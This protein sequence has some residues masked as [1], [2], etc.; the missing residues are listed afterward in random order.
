VVNSS[1]KSTA[2]KQRVQEQ[3]AKDAK[4]KASDLKK[5][6]KALK[7][8]EKGA[9]K[10]KKV[11]EAKEVKRKA[12]EEAADATKAK[13]EAKKS[14]TTKPTKKSS[15]KKA[16]VSSYD[17]DSDL[18]DKDDEVDDDD[19]DAD[20]DVDDESSNDDESESEEEEEEGSDN[21][22]DDSDDDDLLEGLT[23]E[24]L[25]RL[26]S[27]MANQKATESKG[28]GL[29]TLN[30]SSGLLT[31]FSN[32]DEAYMKKTMASGGKIVGEGGKVEV[33]YALPPAAR[34]NSGLKKKR[35]LPSFLTQ[36][37]SLE[38]LMASKV[39][40]NGVAPQGKAG[41]NFSIGGAQT[42]KISAAKMMRKM[43]GKKNY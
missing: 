23:P 17:E 24:E 6:E 8:A 12:E 39:G 37:P 26:Q 28:K 21:D 19:L 10:R 15:S 11:E 20:L 25:T 31:K 29:N 3:T 43:G 34:N 16:A 41:A 32:D 4:R 30:L 33:V 2:Q 1:A 38:V 5:K 9:E 13:K 14:K 27:L 7:E 42:K 40:R 22:L 35:K 36:Q 18:D